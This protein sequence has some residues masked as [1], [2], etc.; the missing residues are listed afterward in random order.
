M[1]KSTLMNEH[2]TCHFTKEFHNLKALKSHIYE[3]HGKRAFCPICLEHKKIFVQ[4]QE[5]YTPAQLK[6]HIDKGK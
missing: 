4:E 2:P 6:Q 1:L 5:L 3:R